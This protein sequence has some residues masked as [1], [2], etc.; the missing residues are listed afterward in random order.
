MAISHIRRWVSAAAMAVTAVACSSAPEAEIQYCQTT[1][2]YFIERVWAPIVSQKCVACH[3]PYG[4]ARDSRLVLVPET[5]PGFI[6]ENL[7]TMAEVAS[8][9]IGGL[10]ALLLKPTAQ[11]DHGGGRQI[12]P[13]SP[14]YEALSEL[15]HRFNDGEACAPLPVALR[16]PGVALR[17]NP[18]TLYKASLRL[19]GR[20]PTAAEMERASAGEVAFDEALTAMMA[21]PAF[22]DGIKRMFQADHLFSPQTVSEV[23]YPVILEYSGGEF[24]D[25]M[26]S[27]GAEPLE[28]IAH[29]VREGR[30]FTEI[31]TAEYT[32][33]NP[34]TAHIYGVEDQV[35]FSDPSDLGEYQ[36][37]R[38][39]VKLGAGE[40][41]MPHAGILTTPSFLRMNEPG[42]RQRHRADAVYRRLLG[43]DLSLIGR[44]SFDVTW[45]SSDF[46]PAMNDQSCT[47]C[48]IQLDAVAGTFMNFGGDGHYDPATKPWYQEM[49]PP[50]FDGVGVPKEDLGI[51]HQIL[52]K[53][54]AKDP[55]FG[56]AVAR[57][58]YRG[59][60][61]REPMPYPAGAPGP[62]QAARLRRFMAED[63]FL[64]S[65]VGA[66]V[67]S[68][69]DIR[70]LVRWIV[71]SP[72][73]R[74]ISVANAPA[75]TEGQHEDLGAMRLLP[76]DLLDKKLREVTGIDKWTSS[77]AEEYHFYYPLGGAGARF[78]I[79]E[80]AEQ[81][82]GYMA[83]LTARIAREMACF[84]GPVDFTRAPGERLL[85]PYVE[86]SHAPEEAGGAPDPD[87]QAAIRKNIR[88]LH[89]RL[90]GEQLAEGDPE[91]ERTYSLFVDTYREGQKALASSAA[92]EELPW[93]CRTA[94]VLPSIPDD[95]DIASDPTFTIRV[96]MAVLKAMLS[97]P[98]FLY[99]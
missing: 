37:A 38:L 70:T 3:T 33:V 14:D 30:P 13:G 32:V 20:L 89:A 40:V 82:S 83:W 39:N 31:L 42:I 98:S 51:A 77:L 29:V 97:D 19:V 58:V 64:R 86:P 80:A 79:A 26:K 62:E 7:A 81:Q 15:V 16:Y 53:E 28:L 35:K 4:A 67:E 22:A 34:L 47:P 84:A 96:W 73:F 36:V 59:L 87:A 92:A 44:G 48:H 8:Y 85:F 24:H 52:A 91:I 74:A 60:V 18:A 46:N 68:G 27:I 6:D 61:G 50:G 17:T 76:P 41:A 75:G 49:P 25:V 90:F 43:T 63:T 11:K 21:E 9:S 45:T 10:S 71:K 78:S 57:V 2:E 55:R 23:K 95:K 1:R 12:D 54:I 56:W 93:A 88:F 69:H 5:E 65:A 99:E 66:F 72:Y 94:N